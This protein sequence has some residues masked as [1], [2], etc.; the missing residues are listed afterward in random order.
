M[1]NL[2]KMI[3]EILSRD[4]INQKE[5]AK[6]LKVAPAQISKWKDNAVPKL[7]N[8]QKLEAIYKG[9]KYGTKCNQSD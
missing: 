1:E 7:E 4:G 2:K 8:Y 5:L 9:G 3:E 6:K